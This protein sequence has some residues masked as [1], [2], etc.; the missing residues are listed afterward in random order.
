MLPIIIRIEFKVSP[1]TFCP[2]AKISFVFVTSSYSWAFCSQAKC[3]SGKES[4]ERE[5]QGSRWD[6][7]TVA[8][9]SGGGG[10][11]A[12]GGKCGK[13]CFLRTQMGLHKRLHLYHRGLVLCLHFM[14]PSKFLLIVFQSL[15]ECNPV[16]E[17]VSY[18]SEAL[19]SLFF[20]DSTA[21]RGFS[22]TPLVC[23]WIG[24]GSAHNFT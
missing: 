16:F 3:A 19:L 17:L 18:S 10:E 11:R 2:P 4:L 24:W 14:C 6:R 8:I 9:V 7:D 1:L 13:S 23:R 20:K 22:S 5:L 21:V 15:S 12:V